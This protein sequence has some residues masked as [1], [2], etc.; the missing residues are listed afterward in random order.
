MESE[1]TIN[2]ESKVTFNESTIKMESESTINIESHFSFRSSNEFILG[3]KIDTHRSA[4]DDGYKHILHQYE[5]YLMKGMDYFFI[6]LKDYKPFVKRELM[7]KILFKFPFVLYLDKED[8]TKYKISLHRISILAK[9]S[10]EDIIEPKIEDI[11][12]KHNTSPISSPESP[13]KTGKTRFSPRKKKAEYNLDDV[14]L[15]GLELFYCKYDKQHS[16]HV[17]NTMMQNICEKAD[18]FIVGLTEDFMHEMMFR[19]TKTHSEIQDYYL[20]PPTYKK[21]FWLP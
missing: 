10:G 13:Q 2:M 3:N 12:K 7:K 19:D 20:V 15:Y 6:S 21:F 8:I 4:I 1:S 18:Y 11:I 17:K 16:S 14:D 9:L 5:E